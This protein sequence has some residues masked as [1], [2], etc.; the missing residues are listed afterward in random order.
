MTLSAGSGSSTIATVGGTT[1]GSGVATFTVKDATAETVTYTAHDTTDSV[2]VT[3]TAAVTFTAAAPPTVS[4]AQSTVS[5]APTSV[6]ADGSTTSTISVTLKDSGG[7]AVSG[8]TV[9]LTAGAGSSTISAVS[10]TT[11]GSGVASFTVKD[12]TA[13][14]VTYTAHDTTDSVDVTNTATVTFTAT[15]SGGSTSSGGTPT[16]AGASPPTVTISADSTASVGQNVPFTGGATDPNGVAI[17]SYVWSLGDGGSATGPTATHRYT[18]AGTYAVTLSATDTLGKTGTTTHTIVVSPA[19]LSAEITYSPAPAV[20]GVADSLHVNLAPGGNSVHS[21]TWSFPGGGTASGATVQ[22]TF[23]KAGSYAVTVTAT[24]ASGATATT[25][26]DIV[27]APTALGPVSASKSGVSAP[28]AATMGTTPIHVT[29]AVRDAYGRA[30]AGKTVQLT[31]S[32]HAAFPQSAH[33]TLTTNTGGAAVFSVYDTHAE[34][35]TFTAADT[36]DNV[37]LAGSATTSFAAPASDARSTVT[38]SPA[39]VPADGTSASTVTVTLKDSGGH[40]LSGK[41]V[42]VVTGAGPGTTGQLH[43]KEDPADSP[44]T[45]ANG[46]ATFTFTDTSPETI[47]VRPTDATD[48]VPLSFVDIRFQATA[49][50]PASATTSTLVADPSMVAAGGTSTGTVTATLRNA[51]GGP[52]PGASVTLHGASAASHI[53][54]P[55]ATTDANGKAAFTVSD[56]K[57]QS[58]VYS[59]TDT[60]EGIAVGQTAQVTFYRPGPSATTS[61]TV[62]SPANV[63]SDGTSP[64][65]ITVT[66]LDAGGN[67]VPEMRL[68]LRKSSTT[69]TVSPSTATTNRNGVATFTSADTATESVTYTPQLESSSV[70][71]PTATVGFANMHVTAETTRVVGTT[72]EKWDVLVHLYQGSASLRGKRVDLVP[73]AGSNVTVTAEQPDPSTNAGVTDGTGRAKFLVRAQHDGTVVLDV[74]DQTDNVLLPGS[75][76]PR[77]LGQP[78]DG[79]QHRHD[80]PPLGRG[81][82]TERRDGHRDARRRLRHTGRRPGGRPEAL[83]RLDQGAERARLGRLDGDGRHRHGRLPRARRDGRGG[84]DPRVRA[85]LPDERARAR[86]VADRDL[87]HGLEHR[88]RARRS[89]R[90]RPTRS[91]PLTGRRRGTSPS[92]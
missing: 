41:T 64:S 50:G 15:S 66:L 24:A 7:T 19:Q 46:V 12:A 65:T 16:Q 53:A 4:A 29:V 8:K 51:A 13:E 28:A 2:D 85:A 5:A 35:V 81:G 67:P 84:R 82:W 48:G 52:V 36:T 39:H 62:A 26:K 69:A 80:L 20:A 74:R 45:N 9:T 77:V 6:A 47:T 10:G 90:S 44:V 63:P 21:A 72:P 37:T 58:V 32:G 56:P 87:R 54:T 31:A 79:T 40:P 73:P 43:V 88:G 78:F 42:H 91:C 38:V 83:L 1:N 92:R 49:G 70:A 23:A 18:T 60:S 11:N 89:R 34:N 55:T 30:I 86:P 33:D 68:Q 76:L 61:T 75:R 3:Q 59:A 17:V 27:V 14:T 71:L 22:H 57:A 25:E